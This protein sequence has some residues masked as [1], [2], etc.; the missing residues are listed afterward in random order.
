MKNRRNWIAASAVAAALFAAVLMGAEKPA[1]EK[2]PGGLPPLKVSKDAPPLLEET[3]KPMPAAKNSGPVADNQ[4][5]LVCHTNYQGESMA[6]SHAQGNV[7]CVGCHGQSLAHRNDE[8]NVTPPDI[9]YPANKINANCAKCHEGHDVAPAKMVQR[10]E[11]RS[12]D[13]LDPK[14]VLCTDC[15]GEHRLKSRT[16]RWDKETRTILRPPAATPGDK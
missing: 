13:R 6:V 8:D 9:I 15:H 4:S 5:C 14:L 16:I 10:W 7:G 12:L 2:K 3:A 11:D 1:A